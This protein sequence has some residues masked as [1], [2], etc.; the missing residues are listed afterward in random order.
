MKKFQGLMYYGRK[1][2][3]KKIGAVISPETNQNSMYSTLF[4][5]LCYRD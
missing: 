1:K 3:S 5:Q 2:V 4:Y